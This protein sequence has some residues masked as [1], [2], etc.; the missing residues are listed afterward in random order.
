M[1]EPVLL[2]THAL[3]WWVAQPERLSAPAA[4]AITGAALSS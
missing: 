1:T 4:D 2:D 3:M